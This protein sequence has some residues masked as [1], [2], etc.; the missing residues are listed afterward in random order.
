MSFNALA[1][2]TSALR[3]ATGTALPLVGIEQVDLGAAVLDRGEL[4]RKIVRVL[5][6]GVE[7]E[8]AGRGEPVRGVADEKEAPVHETAARP[9]R[10]SSTS[11][12]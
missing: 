3:C 10:S 9:A 6:A 4:P 8:P 2:L 5:H 7:P 11:R 12:S 1:R